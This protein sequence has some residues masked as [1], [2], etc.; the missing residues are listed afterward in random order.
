MRVVLWN[1]QILRSQH[2]GSFA[3][4]LTRGVNAFQAQAAGVDKAAKF[5]NH[6]VLR[7][8][9]LLSMENSATIEIKEGEWSCGLKKKEIIIKVDEV[10]RQAWNAPKETLQGHGVEGGECFL[11]AGI[12]LA[13]IDNTDAVRLDS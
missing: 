13:V 12:D 3:T 1:D 9:F 6:S 8:I 5:L 11:I 2:S 4:A 7:E 10:I